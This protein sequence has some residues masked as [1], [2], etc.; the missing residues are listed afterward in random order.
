[1]VPL[2]KSHMS[3]APAA[4][5]GR[6]HQKTQI[7]DRERGKRLL[8]SLV[9][10][11]RGE[12]DTDRVSFCPPLS[13]I[14]SSV[15]LKQLHR[16]RE[17]KDQRER[18]SCFQVFQSH[19]KEIKEDN[20]QRKKTYE[21]NVK[22]LSL[23]SVPCSQFVNQPEETFWNELLWLSLLRPAQRQDAD[24]NNARE[25]KAF[26]IWLQIEWISFTQPQKHRRT[27]CPQQITRKSDIIQK[28]VSFLQHPR[29]Q[30]FFVSINTSTWHILLW[31]ASLLLHTLHR[32]HKTATN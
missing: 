7:T 12:R 21:Q 18:K 11:M 13:L 19:S 9:W 32:S 16:W 3:H 25:D 20:E 6:S 15:G 8:M 29:Q 10:L 30:S 23:E 28:E 26:Q 31:R 24:G 1:M 14:W 17:T 4:Q 5:R 2:N 22:R 27:Y